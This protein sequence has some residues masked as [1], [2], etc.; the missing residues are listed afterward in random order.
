[1]RMLIVKDTI[2]AQYHAVLAVDMPDATYILDNQSAHVLKH[3]EIK[4]N[5]RHV[6]EPLFALAR[7][8]SWLY[9]LQR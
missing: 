6:Y 8:K 7:D 3:D 4:V 9:G 2:S 5:G 1:M